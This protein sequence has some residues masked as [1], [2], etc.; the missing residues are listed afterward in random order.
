MEITI[1]LEQACTELAHNRIKETTLHC[2]HSDVFIYN[3]ET[4]EEIFT[5]EYQRIFDGWYNYYFY[6]LKS[7]A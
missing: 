2:N 4:N 1:N 5:D 7:I 3:S 6:I